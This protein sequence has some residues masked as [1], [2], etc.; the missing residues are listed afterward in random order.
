MIIEENPDSLLIK[1]GIDVSFVDDAMVELRNIMPG[2]ISP[3][4]ELLSKTINNAYAEIIEDAFARLDQKAYLITKY[5]SENVITISSILAA[6]K[7]DI[8]S[9]FNLKYF[10]WHLYI[11]GIIVVYIGYCVLTAHEG[12]KYYKSSVLY[13]EGAENT[14]TGMSGKV[15]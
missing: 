8:F 13:G 3:E 2:S 4:N 15:K 12:K 9:Y 10:R 11:L 5:S 1:Q 14:E 7:N 6:L